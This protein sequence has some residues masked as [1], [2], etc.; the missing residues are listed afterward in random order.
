MGTPHSLEDRIAALPEHLRALARQQLAGA[1]AA[2]DS[3]PVLSRD[4]PLPLSPAQERLWFLYEYEPRGVEYNALKVLRLSGT[5]DERAL[6]GAVTSVVRRHESLRTVFETVD[7]EGRQRVTA[8]ADVPMTRID[9]TQV[10]TVERDAELQRCLLD[11]ALTPFDLRTGPVLRLVLVRLAADEHVLG[12]SMHH[13]V[14][15]GW[16]VGVLVEELNR[17]Y[18]AEVRGEAAE[19]PALPVQYADVA[20]WLRDQ[21]NDD[22]LGYWLG[23]LDGLTP[24]E[25]PTDR[26]RPTVRDTEGALYVFEVPAEVV[27]GLKVVSRDADATLFMTLV[28]ATQ[29][30]F[31]RYT[32]ERDVAVATLTSGRDRPELERLIGFFVNTLV[33]RSQVD[34][35][36]P[37][38]DLLRAVRSTVLDAFAHQEVPFQR[39]VDR[40]APPRDQGRPPLVQVMVNLQ[41]APGGQVRLPGLSVEELMPPAR[42]ASLDVTIDFAEQAGALVG[43]IEYSTALFDEETMRWLS[44]HLVTLLTGIADEPERPM[45][46]LTMLSRN[47]LRYLLAAGTGERIGF[48]EP[49]C[50]HEVFAGQ[51][52]STPDEPAVIDESGTITFAELDRRA[53]QLAH[54]LIGLGVRPGVLV[55]VCAERSS[56]VV[57]ALLAVLKAGGAFVPL[58]PDYP[59]HQLAGMLTDAAAPV[60]LTQQHLVE[61]LPAGDTSVLCLD[62]DAALIDREPITAP[63]TAVT[64][65]DLAYVVYTSGSTGRPKGVMVEHRNVHHMVH[66]WDAR[67]GLAGTRPRSL[68]VSSLGVDLFFAD[69]LMSALLGGTIVVCPAKA[70]GDP[71]ELANLIERTE[72]SL[73]VTVPSLARALA[74]EMAWRGRR[75]ESLRVLAV[76]S[77]G[78]PIADVGPVLERVGPDTLV[79]NAYGATETTV[80]STVFA[81]DGELGAG[82]YVPIGHPLAN[83]RVYLLDSLG[84]PVPFGVAGEVY[85]GGAGIARGYWNLPELSEQRFLADPFMSEP[86]HRMYRTGDLARR[87]RDGALEFLGRVDD[88]V[89]IRG[90]RVELGEVEAALTEHP[91][92]TA[93]AATTR[94]DDAG[95]LRLVAYCEVTE[96]GGFDVAG[97]RA[98]LRTRLPAHAVPSAFVLLDALP[99]SPAGTLNRRSLP[100]PDWAAQLTQ[101]YRAPGTETEAALAG[102]WAE[103]LG[104]PVARVGALDNFFELGGDSILSLRVISRIRARF[105][106]ALSPRHLFDAPTVVELAELIAR[107]SES[108]GAAV[109]PRSDVDGPAPLSFAQQRLWFLHDFAPNGTEYHSGLGLRLRGELDVGA[110]H[111]ALDQLLARHESLRTTFGTADG[112]PVQIVHAPGSMPSTTIDLSGQPEAALEA[113]LRQ[114]LSQPFDLSAGPLCRAL[115]IRLDQD[116][117]V[118][119]LLM[120]HIVTD[121]WSMGVLAGEL[122]PCYA[123]AL[124]GEQARLTELPVRYADYALWQRD[125]ES[126]PD[127]TEHASYW[128]DRLAG[129]GQLDLP[130]D[131]P[132]PAV[133]SSAG[134]TWTVRAPDSLLR[135]LHAVARQGD[136][137]LFMVLLAATKILLARYTGQRDIAVGAASAGRDRAEIEGLVGFFVNTVVLRSTVDDDLTFADFL[138]QVRSTV[139]EA[140]AHEQLPF[141]QLVE[142][143]R[144]ARDP[145]RTP[146]VEVMVVMQN[147]PDPEV[148]MPGLRAEPVT[149]G[150]GDVG[151]DLNLEFIEQAGQFSV[152]LRY[153]TALFDESTMDRMAGQLLCLLEAI[154]A[155]AARPVRE[156]PLLTA[157]ERDN[158]LV[159]WNDTA[160]GAPVPELAELIARPPAEAQHRTAVTSATNDAGRLD[161]AEL[162]ARANRLAHHLAARG[163]G[164][165]RV[166]GVACP[167]TAD[168]VVAML[169][170]LKAGAAFLPLDVDHPAERLRYVVADAQP[171]LVLA[172][173]PTA[174]IAAALPQGT[175]CLLLDDPRTIADLAALPATPIAPVRPV[176]PGNAAYL[177]YTSGSTGAP[178]GVLVPRHNLA[179]FLVDMIDRLPLTEC[180]RLLAVT[181]A[182]F[183]I[184]N[185]ELLAP[186]VAGATVAIADQA[187]THDPQALGMAIGATGTTIMQATP[188][189][190]RAV[191]DESERAIAGLRVLVGGEALAPDLADTLARNAAS[192]L[193]VYGPTE[194]TIYST[195]APVLATRTASPPIGA[196]ISNT[197]VY[198]LDA[199]LRPV[200]QGV[201]GELYIAGDGVARGYLGRGALTAARFVADPFTAGGGRMYRTG[202]VVRWLDGGALEYL[203]RSDH[204]VK[205]RGFRIELGEIE[206]VLATHPGVRAATVVVRAE[207]LVAYVVP[208]DDPPST[209]DLIRFARERL[210]GYMVPAHFA[211]LAEFPLNPSGKVDRAALGARDIDD[212][213]T[214]EEHVPP[215]DE[216]E[217]VLAGIWAEALG[218]EAASVGV[219]DN[220]FMLGGD[221]LLSM[222][223]VSRARSAGLPLESRQLFL[224]QTIA[225]LATALAEDDAPSPATPSPAKQ[226]AP[227]RA[228]AG[229]EDI[230]PLTPM[231]S[232]ML[233]HSLATDE[234][235]VYLGHS[236]LVLDGVTDPDALIR[237]WQTVAERTPVLRTAIDWDET[238]QPVQVVYQNVALPVSRHD[239]TGLPEAAARAE[240]ERLWAEQT[241]CTVDLGT[242]P[243]LRLTLLRLSAER[244]EIFWSAHHIL[245]DGWSRANLWADVFACYANRTPPVRP[246]FGDY[247]RWLSTQDHE[248]A[249]RHW[250][251]VVAGFAA[252]TPLP[253]DRPSQESQGVRTISLHLPADRAARLFHRCR[254]LRIT[255]ATLVQGAWAILLARHGGTDDVIFGLTVSG[256]PAELAGAEDMIGLFI[257]T[258]PVRASF[259]DERVSL[260]SW[261]REL[262]T[263]QANGQHHQYTSLARIKSFSDVPSDASLF[264]SIVVLEQFPEDVDTSDPA[265]PRV[266]GSAD[267]MRTNY[268]LTL[269]ADIGAELELSLEYDPARFDESTVRR[270]IAHLDTLFDAVL[271]DP[272]IQLR[273]LSVL[274]SAERQLV[275]TEWNDT[276]AQV[277]ARGLHEL[278]MEQAERSPDAIAVASGT[279]SLTYRELADRTGILAGYLAGQGVGPDV[280]VGVCAERGID[281]VVMLLGVL[282]AGGGY[283]P[284]DPGYPGER[285][286][287]MVADATPAVIL[288]QQHLA[289]RLPEPGVPVLRV[290]A[291]WPAT[292]LPVPTAP[293]RPETVAYAIYTSG[294]T[295]RPKGVLVSHRAIVNRLAWMQSRYRLS[296]EDRVLQ[297]TPFSFDVSV[298]EFFWPLLTGATLVMARPGGHR[299]PDYLA[300]VIRDERITT[301]HFVPSMLREFLA[302]PAVAQCTELRRVFCSGEALPAALCEQYFQTLTAPLHNLYGPTEAAVDVTYWSCRPGAE[303]VPIGS[304]VW[305][306]KVQVLDAALRPVPPGVPGELY[307][308]G[309]QLARGYHARPG[310][311]AQRFVAAPHGA[312]GERM[313]RTGD[314]VRWLPDGNLEYL[315][316]TD[317][318]VKI[319]GVRI[320]LGEVEA[321]LAAHPDIAAV[322]AIAREARPGDLRLVAYVVARPSAAPD[323]AQL[324]AFLAAR[325]P[326]HLVPSAF[327]SLPAL[328]TTPSGKLDRR[329]LP[330]PD[331]TR[332]GATEHVAPGTEAEQALARIWAE[333][334]DLP[335][336]RIGVSDDF[337]AIGGNSLLSIQVL[338][339]ARGE[340]FDLT[341]RDLLGRRTIA[342]LAQTAAPARPEPAI[343]ELPLASAQRALLRRWPDGAPGFLHTSL[344]E[345]A[346]GIDTGALG[347]ALI[348]LAGRH[349]ALRMRFERTATGWRQSPAPADRPDPLVRHTLAP[350]PAGQR[351]RAVA[352]LVGRARADLAGGTLLLAT[353]VEFEGADNPW[354]W[355]AVHPLAADAA[356]W[357]LLLD[358]LA[359]AYR[360]ACAGEA[361]LPGAAPVAFAD[362]ARRL[363]DE[364]DPVAA[365]VAA[366]PPAPAELVVRLHRR[367]SD[368]LLRAVPPLFR[369]GIDVV[370]AAVTAQV[371]ARD[372]GRTRVLLGLPDRVRGAAVPDLDVSGTIG[373]LTGISTVAVDVA[374]ND[375]TAL[376]QSVRRQL[377]TTV[378]AEPDLVLAYRDG[379]D[380][381]L[382]TAHGEFYRAFHGAIGQEHGRPAGGTPTVI[383]TLVDGRLE[384]HWPADLSQLANAFR[385]ALHDL[386]RTL[387][388]IAGAA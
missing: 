282:R 17:C 284:L 90:F 354:L 254:E 331:F 64:P 187:L 67:Y 351:R 190:W 219:T 15:D 191:V 98:F 86:G 217:R 150:G 386:V 330:A 144:P 207:R 75:L 210:P 337:F 171:A 82:P 378:P 239:L 374:D 271:A 100:E 375:W 226:V 8:N 248:A 34:E 142:L 220:F 221:S 345:L 263:A 44:R 57:V 2:D 280:L 273:D 265:G 110:L 173:A 28:A 60:L 130:T 233:F 62:R 327:V 38:A 117:H 324:R 388:P 77:E 198:V 189:L 301:V 326:A 174:A 168:L 184:A 154:T 116:D 70:V 97:L 31:A 93:A 382:L 300:T 3:I 177:I 19:L 113:V 63:E 308:L 227:V 18:A 196:P 383:G 181:T 255:A 288:T 274:T 347:A 23:Q 267:E 146:L 122:G 367:D 234:H 59:A 214:A 295:G 329:A 296:P 183:D 269:L 365:E 259:G 46:K 371:L 89:K 36:L 245:L 348:A 47:E 341:M 379:A 238:G 155:D 228:G 328:P 83:T 194:T 317:H 96:P 61:R 42:V 268:P 289:Q 376:I 138:A 32:G 359:R 188:S 92:V 53:N 224:N 262:Q 203:G 357:P 294:T 167:R 353:L 24:L 165:E 253:Y 65:A 297:K 192:A 356:S 108:A 342:A 261:L 250:R 69:F 299:E 360:S 218:V 278:I 147:T 104:V 85:I 310:L 368:I 283:L 157:T 275:L 355:L 321:A 272:D 252:P 125:S 137:S 43:Y 385:E 323:D 40:L 380:T 322:T 30:L 170:V 95:H 291:D 10:P 316:R 298:W 240:A 229:V 68:C 106:V 247:V 151:Y 285:L 176:H 103:V 381:G 276:L 334:L 339:R 216:T 205:I 39:L 178:K 313:Y 72:A 333:V 128:Q 33:L 350:T 78:W 52:L 74:E 266:V 179:N 13:I 162:H 26:P 225:E 35:S 126:G 369:T 140:A 55:G 91:A 84:R 88:Q 119:A 148:E 158:I 101:D 160:G 306:T 120:H 237:A 27:S 12:L 309:T 206:A 370:L 56:A 123:A 302:E 304:P 312:P 182:G 6:A 76:G 215:R 232:G 243:L 223:V 66:A 251:Q 149:V 7:G 346:P 377:R 25:L 287:M 200:P 11:E 14:S 281:L 241:R 1:A 73:L 349:D 249:E 213:G 153:S 315:G 175:D 131:R 258:V 257:N 372:T 343:G 363:A 102:I 4:N 222:K 264:D 58:D 303:R 201:H 290:D 87:R 145:S 366:A 212:T 21:Q 143:M 235:D 209:A 270:L 358:E 48:G 54:H 384:V 99:L 124:R 105:D 231:Q 45:S 197:S 139:L 5:L 362:W 112:Q 114:E 164:P 256:R 236:R 169:A 156:L 193:N 20:S 387:G 277:P 49:R 344:L 340:G 136:A 180:D 320:E 121:G 311:T 314:L 204:Q 141:E 244:V 107:S 22:Q 109:I 159:G 118:L 202:D 115:L 335:V 208:A 163:V 71:V 172:C 133:R 364:P 111:S 16:S 292:P 152:T 230:Y 199:R 29:L 127:L 246:P 161:F 211:T 373:A 319:R 336:E 37:F 166:V 293:T 361:P 50:V 279:E 9:L 260:A 318:Q 195:T 79:V 129:L 80:D 185:L 307:L 325:L 286:A 135:G 305:N 186:V 41:N 242:A 132:R 332:G 338:H 134:A 51:A 352:G 81:V 94:P